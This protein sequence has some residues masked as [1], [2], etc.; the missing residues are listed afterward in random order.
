MEAA[1]FVAA[2][3][4]CETVPTEVIGMPSVVIVVVTEGDQVAMRFT[5]KCGC[6]GKSRPEGRMTSIHGAPARLRAY[7]EAL[8]AGGGDGAAASPGRTVGCGSST[9]PLVRSILIASKKTEP[10][11][12]TLK[13]KSS[14]PS[15]P[16]SARAENPVLKAK[17][18]SFAAAALLT[19]ASMPAPAL[20][21]S[22]A[23]VLTESRL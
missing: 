12:L 15:N 9:W 19:V 8:P 16:I 21:R 13:L 1:R 4:G 3:V 6:R 2:R 5:P 11:G 17:A 20:F 10:S 14:L 7:T 23:V 22:T 18:A